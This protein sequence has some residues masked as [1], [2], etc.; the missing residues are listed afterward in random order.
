MI[1]LHDFLQE[2]TLSE[3]HENPTLLDVLLVPEVNQSLLQNF[4]N[5][6]L[7]DML[8]DGVI[9]SLPMIAGELKGTNHISQQSVEKLFENSFNIAL[10]EFEKM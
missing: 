8:Y 2:A 3:I 5:I 9:E 10:K 7:F 6:L 1:Q 4:Q